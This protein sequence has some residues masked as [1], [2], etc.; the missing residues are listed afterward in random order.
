MWNLFKYH[1]LSLI[2]NKA[3]L[4]WSIIFPILLST[5]L[6]MTV[7][8]AYTSATLETIQIAVINDEAYRQDTLF[9]T[10][11]RE[12]SA[13]DQALFE[14]IE[15]EEAEADSLLDQGNIIAYITVDEGYTAHVN[16]SGL[17]QTVI[18]TF[19]D[20]YMQQQM[21]MQELMQSGA[22][23]MT[24][25]QEMDQ[26]VSYIEATEENG[27][28]ACVYFFSILAMTSLYGGYWVLRNAQ[29]QT[30]DQSDSGK[31]NAIAPVHPAQRL[32]VD[33]V[34][35]IGM[36]FLVQL[37]MLAY[38]YFVLQVDF[39]TDLFPVLL[40]LITGTF[41][42]NSLGLLVS[43]YG[44]K[45]YAKKTS[46]LTAITLIGCMLSGMM[47]VQMKFYVQQWAPWLAA[48]NPANMITDA[49]YANYYYGAG[50]RFYM[51]ILS[52]LIFTVFAYGIGYQRLRRK[53]YDSL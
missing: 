53:Q 22:D 38:M 40:V 46:V 24:L 2:R 37:I 48:I 51:N 6:Q 20:E 26:T 4:F 12:V 25:L 9:Q 39:G 42:G 1:F 27:N 29:S 15:C 30:A 14:I 7:A 10:V 34:I 41:A 36:N 33:F 8:N 17:E 45:D 44:K 32:F 11:L 3:I 5:F 28:L 13:N 35:T 18:S 31:R 23:P 47:F 19:L 52:L 21:I 50:E 16:A 49:L 43:M